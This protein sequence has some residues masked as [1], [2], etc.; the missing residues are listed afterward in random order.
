MATSRVVEKR[1]VLFNLGLSALKIR[2]RR[3]KCGRRHAQVALLVQAIL[4]CEREIWMI[5]IE[6]VGE[7]NPTPPQL[8]ARRGWECTTYTIPGPSR[9]PGPGPQAIKPNTSAITP[10]DRQY[11]SQKM[12][13]LCQWCWIRLEENRVDGAARHEYFS[14]SQKRVYSERFR[15]NIR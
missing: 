5:G 1:R 11:I 7:L 3:W 8:Y 6:G 12:T 4:V 10:A 13:S 2:W 14:A 9:A 15:L